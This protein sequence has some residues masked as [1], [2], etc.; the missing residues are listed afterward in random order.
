MIRAARIVFRLS[1]VAAVLWL[2]FWSIGFLVVTDQI[3][4]GGVAVYLAFMAS[5]ALAIVAVGALLAWAL[6]AGQ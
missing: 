1:V 6:R 4:H 2:A 3:V 5:G